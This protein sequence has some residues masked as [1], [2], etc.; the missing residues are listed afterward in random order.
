MEYIIDTH[1][2]IW[3]LEGNEKLT[4]NIIQIIEDKK[5]IIFLSI[6][7]LWEISIKLI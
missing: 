7:S 2:L 6:A 4:N 3:Y 1:V 5:N